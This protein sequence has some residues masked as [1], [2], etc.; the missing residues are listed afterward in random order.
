MLPRSSNRYTLGKKDR[1]DLFAAAVA[2]QGVK[3]CRDCREFTG[4]FVTN[5]LVVRTPVEHGQVLLQNGSV[6]SVSIRG[7]EILT[8][9]IIRVMIL[10][11]STRAPYFVIATNTFRLG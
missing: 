5:S 7:N 9:R 1:Q 11:Q 6:A 8:L 4:K 10:Q 3:A 2:F